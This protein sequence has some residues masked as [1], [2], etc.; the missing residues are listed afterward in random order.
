M[1]VEY[2]GNEIEDDMFNL[3]HED[4]FSIG[5]VKVDINPITECRTGTLEEYL[6]GVEKYLAEKRCKAS[7][8]KRLKE[9]QAAVKENAGKAEKDALRKI[10]DVR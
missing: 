2:A 5:G 1:V 9:K 10:E 4:K 3:L 6:P 7:V 8:R